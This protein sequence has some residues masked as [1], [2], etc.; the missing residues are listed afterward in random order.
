MTKEKKK[1]NCLFYKKKKRKIDSTIFQIH[2]RLPFNLE[3][4]LTRE[5]ER[6]PVK[7]GLFSCWMEVTVPTNSWGKFEGT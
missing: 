1:N 4:G 5:L 2:W 6:D 3:R 7:R